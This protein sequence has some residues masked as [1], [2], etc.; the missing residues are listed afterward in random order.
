MKR[1]MVIAALAASIGCA[2]RSQ[3]AP[4]SM[5]GREGL[6]RTTCD[7]LPDAERT[8]AIEILSSTY[9]HDCC[10]ETLVKCLAHERRCLLAVRLAENICRRAATGQ[11]EDAIKL[12]LSLRARMMQAGR[13][14]EAVQIDLEGAAVAGDPE[15]PIKVVMYAAPRGT[16]CAEILPPLHDAVVGGRLAGKAALVAKPFPMRSNPHSVEA[17]LAFV[18]AHELGAF[19]EFVLYSYARFDDFTVTQ[20]SEWASAVEIDRA[21]FEKLIA[22]P[23]TKKRLVA[24]KMEGLENGVKSTPA[25]FVDGRLYPGAVELDELVDIIEEMYD[26]SRGLMYEG[27]Q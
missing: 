3:P 6:T 10:D 24:G 12:A 16:H 22:D 1:I 27:R 5:S 7:D 25:V 8:R 9:V 13:A 23:A 19:W 18:A 15:A 14:D 26:R 4:A 11:D 21:E 20:Q 17:G 2:G